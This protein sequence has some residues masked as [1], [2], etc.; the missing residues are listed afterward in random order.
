MIALIRK[1]A[2]FVAILTLFI[3][4]ISLALVFFAREHLF[5]GID[6]AIYNQAFWNTLHGRFFAESIT[7]TLYLADHLE[8]ILIPLVPL[9][10]LAPYPLTLTLIQTIAIAS[11]AIPL[12]RLAHEKLGRRW[13]IVVTI[14][15]LFYGA[16][17]NVTL[18]DFHAAAFAMPILGW[19]YYFFE[20]ERFRAFVLTCALALLVREDVSLIII[21]FGLYGALRKR[22]WRWILAPLFM[23]ALWFIGAI[24]I[25]SALNK[26]HYSTY[27]YLAYYSYLGTGFLDIIKNLFLHPGRLIGHLLTPTV[28]LGNMNLLFFLL[29][30]LAFLPL[31]DPK[32]LLLGAPFFAQ[33]FLSSGAYENATIHRPAIVIP[34]LFATAIN[35]LAKFLKRPWVADYTGI[36]KL[37]GA[38]LFIGSSIGLSRLIWVPQQIIATHRAA[39]TP[40]EDDLLARIPANAAVIATTRFLPSL[41][42]RQHLFDSYAA[43]QNG[44]EFTQHAAAGF[45]YSKQPEYAL[46]NLAQLLYVDQPEATREKRLQ[47]EHFF[48]EKHLEPVAIRDA[49]VLYDTTDATPALELIKISGD[50][51]TPPNAPEIAPG[52]LVSDISIQ[53]D[54]KH[55]GYTELP[56]HATFTPTAVQSRPLVARIHITAPHLDETKLIPLGYFTYQTDEWKIGESVTQLFNLVLPPDIDPAH[57]H[58]TLEL[59]DAAG[60]TSFDYSTFLDTLLLHP[61]ALG[62]TVTIQ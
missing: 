28:F 26:T 56:F 53:T 9:Y 57:T 20:R 6:L 58:I 30:P 34:F 46:F 1:H 11:G 37:I 49:T 60:A 25:L 10:A 19:A 13:G 62:A 55:V 33:S 48:A 7:N 24:N 39:T 61:K 18:Y 59:A 52:L 8:L 31:L 51:T 22:S 17:L 42:S 12:Y 44:I 23:G 54:I 40:A 41:S 4:L 36:L 32:T 50:V 15:Y 3:A 35:G 21:C 16:T 45:P 27:K 47:F 29:L 38:G 43:T 2:V 5:Y 14:G